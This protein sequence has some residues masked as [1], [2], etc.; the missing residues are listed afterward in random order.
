MGRGFPAPTKNP[1]LLVGHRVFRNSEPQGHVLGMMGLVPGRR[2]GRGWCRGHPSWAEI[3]GLFS[4]QPCYLRTW[5]HDV[6]QS[7]HSLRCSCWLRVSFNMLCRKQQAPHSRA[8]SHFS[9]RALGLGLERPSN[10]TV[11]GWNPKRKWVGPWG[12]RTQAQ[13]QGRDEKRLRPAQVNS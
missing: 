11:L 7:F 10:H 6:P 2:G 9:L 1:G 5:G 3:K 4:S 13:I 8:F 12:M